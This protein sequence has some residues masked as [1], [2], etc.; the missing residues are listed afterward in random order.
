LRRRAQGERREKEKKSK[1][2]CGRMKAE[3]RT[4]TERGDPDASGDA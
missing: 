1:D 3:G 4:K 2:E